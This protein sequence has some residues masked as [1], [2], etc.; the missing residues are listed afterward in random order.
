VIKI[1]VQ[2]R[3]VDFKF[4]SSDDVPLGNAV[5]W[6]QKLTGEHWIQRITF[7]AE[8]NAA[9]SNTQR[10]SMTDRCW[11]TQYLLRSL[12]DGEGN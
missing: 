12:R 7:A 9:D 1:N 4:Q 11:A 5:S 6:L 8:T 2:E 3:L 10:D